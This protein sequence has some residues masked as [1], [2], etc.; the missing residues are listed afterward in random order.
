M[1]KNILIATSLDQ[2]TYKA[3]SEHLGRQGYKIDYRPELDKAQTAEATQSELLPVTKDYDAVVVGN[4]ALSK[5]FFSEW[6]NARPTGSLLLMRPGTDVSS[7]DLNA[8]SQEGVAVVNTPGTRAQACANFMMAQ[9]M[10]HYIGGEIGQHEQTM[11]DGGP[12]APAP[13][14]DLSHAK[15]AVIGT[16]HIGSH[17]I[18]RLHAITDASSNHITAWSPNFDNEKAAKLGVDR[19][20]SLADTIEGADIICMAADSDGHPIITEEVL[21]HVKPGAMFVS[22]SRFSSMDMD[23]LEKASHRMGAI[24]LDSRE[25]DCNALRASNPNLALKAY[26][27]PAVAYRTQGTFQSESQQIGRQLE[28]FFSRSQLDVCCNPECFDHPR[29]QGLRNSVGEHIEGLASWEKRTHQKSSA[30]ELQDVIESNSSKI[31]AARRNKAQPDSIQGISDGKLIDAFHGETGFK[32]HPDAAKAIMSHYQQRVE[33]RQAAYCES[34]GQSY[35]K[36]HPA[37]LQK[38]AEE[39][40]FAR[41]AKPADGKPAPEFSTSDILIAPYSSTD[42]LDAC[43]RVLSKPRGVMLMPEGYYK[44]VARHLQA[45][46]LSIETFPVDYTHDAKIDPAQMEKKIQLLKAQGIPISGVLFT[47]PGNPIVSQYS[48]EEMEAIGRV[49][50]KHKLPYICDSVFD[51]L[52]PDYV[53]LAAVTVKDE[54]GKEHRMLDQGMTISGNSKA[55]NAAGPEKIGAMLTGDKK[56]RERVDE[57]IAHYIQRETTHLARAIVENTPESYISGNRDALE[58]YQKHARAAIE[59]MN[60]KF[61]QKYGEKP[62]HCMGKSAQ[63]MFLCVEFSDKMAQRMGVQNNVQL[64]EFLLMAAGID[65]VPMM[66]MGSDSMAIRFNI[67]AP[68]KNNNKD[69]KY[70]DEMIERIS[71]TLERVVDKGLTYGAL[72]QD[73]GLELA[74]VQKGKTVTPRRA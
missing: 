12:A 33:D 20:S 40:L 21:K 16:G 18:H 72:A 25:S 41:I 36:R 61:E 44:S 8:A 51:P 31:H 54:D 45:A 1:P 70:V 55:Y 38:L 74:D 34:D 27:T 47:M 57:M 46:G 48:R 58:Q 71:N 63:G 42:M 39:R 17:L 49:L 2:P 7:I 68:R 62:L 52:V 5:T 37:I 35:K 9:I 28:E 32:I 3:W 13:L 69:P 60:E 65:S 67:T 56:M 15:I 14:P 50:V 24:V 73:Y 10:R 43:L 64:A 29:M 66:Q 30:A 22:T 19:A 26:L 4:V 6:A 11:R 59:R 23:A 53:P